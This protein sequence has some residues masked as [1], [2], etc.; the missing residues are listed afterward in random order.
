M[1]LDND[2]IQPDT[3]ELRVR[4]IFGFVV[5]AAVGAAS[6]LQFSGATLGS[7]VL[8]ALVGGLVAGVLARY[9]GD[10]FWSA[11]RWWF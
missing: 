2:G 1:A 8:T 4:F 7:V 5:G 3:F 11:L 10:R 6:L 9:Y